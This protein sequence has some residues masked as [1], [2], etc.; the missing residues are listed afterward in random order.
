M[1][2]EKEKPYAILVFGVPMSGKTQ[3]A[4]KFSQK[5]KAPHLNFEPI[6]GISR[7]AYLSIVSQIALSQQ[8]LVI[9]DGIDTF[10]QREQLREILKS[11]GYK[12]IIIWIQTDVNTVKRRLRTHL[13]SVERAKAYF[14]E[15][16]DQLEAPEDSENAIVISGKHTFEGQLRS[17]LSHLSKL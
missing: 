5:F 8:N 15:R 2:R 12:S 9:D 4:T 10:K 17:V 7:K 16:L 14:E 6:P 11:A 3:F 1:N 13:K